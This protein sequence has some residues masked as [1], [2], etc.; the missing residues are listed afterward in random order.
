MAYYKPYTTA[1]GSTISYITQPMEVLMA[2]HLVIL[3]YGKFFCHR[4]ESTSHIFN[5][6]YIPRL[7]TFRWG[8]KRTRILCVSLI[9]KIQDT[10][11][12]EV[13]NIGFSG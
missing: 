11:Y 13:Q 4:P 1:M 6:L 9:F 2:A 10:P 3:N 12:P 5:L 7:F 8:K